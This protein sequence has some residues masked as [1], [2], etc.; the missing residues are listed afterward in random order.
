MSGKFL[1]QGRR[2]RDIS[3]ALKG[4]ERLILATDRTEGEAI[5]WHGVSC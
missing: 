2:I 1:I 4:A 5:S 3:K